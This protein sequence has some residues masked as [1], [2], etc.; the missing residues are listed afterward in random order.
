MK[1]LVCGLPG[2]GKS[3]ISQYLVE[4]FDGVHINA[5]AVR[6]QYNDWDFSYE[7]R[8][9]Q[10]ERMKHLA[11]GV[12]MANRVA[13]ADFICPTE[14]TRKAFSP[15]FIVFI[16]TISKGRFEDTNLLFEAPTK[17]N[18]ILKAKGSIDTLT[19]RKLH[20]ST[21]NGF[22]LMP[23]D[24]VYK[25]EKEKGIWLVEH[26]WSPEDIGERISVEIH[27]LEVA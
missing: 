8:L 3:T 7:G 17:F 15:D 11:D 24:W 4:C 25:D 10:A 16:D 1:I 2:S 26:G 22:E 18:L 12:V 20:I 21:P 6:E 13:I 23:S 19:K 27:L 14:N 9:R 5:D